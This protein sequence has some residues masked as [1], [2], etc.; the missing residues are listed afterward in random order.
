MKR[1]GF[2][3]ALAALF[4]APKLPATPVKF[5]IDDSMLLADGATIGPFKRDF[6]CTE[7]GIGDRWEV[8]DWTGTIA[9]DDTIVFKWDTGERKVFRP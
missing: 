5:Q 2:L 1:R 8:S 6:Y 3:G 9:D 4:V 7:V